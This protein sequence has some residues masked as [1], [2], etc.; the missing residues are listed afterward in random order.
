MSSSISE[1]ASSFQR[2]TAIYRRHLK[3]Q[4]ASLAAI[5][6]RS[7]RPPDCLDVDAWA[8]KN[9]EL[10]Y[11]V[12]RSPGR[13]S[14][15]DTP[16]QREPLRAFKYSRRV[17][18]CWAAQVGKTICIQ[19]ILGYIIDQ[20]PGPS[21]IVYPVQPLARRRSQKHL[22]PLIQD[23]PSL[24]KHIPP[25]AKLDNFEFQLDRLNVS[26]AWSG[27]PSMMASEPIRFLLRDELDKFKGATQK[28]ADSISLSERR[29]VSYSFLSR[30]FDAS[31][32]TVKDG[33]TWQGLLN[34]TFERFHL[35]CPHCGASHYLKFAQFKFP[36]KTEGEDSKDYLRRVAKETF[37]EC[38]AC[39]KPIRDKDKFSM[40]ERGVWIPENPQADYRSF[41]LPSWY[42]PW[43][44]F[45]D[46]A[47]R[48]VDAQDDLSALRDVVNSDFAEPW[49]E[50]GRSV[51]LNFILAHK[52]KSYRR[53]EIP[54][55]VPGII[56]VTVD[57]QLDH[58][59]F[60][61]RYHTRSKSYL[62]DEGILPGFDSLERVVETGWKNP[63][64]EIYVPYLTAIDYG[65]R[66]DDVLEYCETHG[67]C[68]AIKGVE[69]QTNTMRWSELSTLPTKLRPLSKTVQLMT[70]HTVSY[71]EDF[72]LLINR[73]RQDDGSL[74]LD[75]ASWLLHSDASDAY[76]SQ[77]TAEMPVDI[78]D[79]LGH[80][81]RKWKRLRKDNHYLDLEVYQLASRSFLRQLLASLP[82]S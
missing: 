18:L 6:S 33:P 63:Q 23:S 68:F 60:A 12:G 45:G 61:A 58:L 24:A 40:L 52:L 43:V 64:G 71:K 81:V 11:R 3:D 50:R 41:H 25:G 78:P 82:E 20:D 48:F 65:Y 19:T 70:I 31:T 5:V 1:F 56:L 10:S 49:E 17:V 67:K 15:A 72:L 62:V 79:K 47:A 36:S 14:F 32:P 9:L 77:I 55:S 37:Y 46:V 57:V 54:V 13:I 22:K 53:G 42:A 38:E 73:G 27:S 75:Q 44:S 7:L 29:T 34:G 30:I 59:Y 80:V 76:A 69:T 8:E 39:R 21:L 4:L 35:P 51:D 74:D 66:P 28:E 26:I 16:Y 2:R